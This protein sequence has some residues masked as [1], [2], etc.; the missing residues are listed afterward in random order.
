MYIYATPN[1]VRQWLQ[2]SEKKKNP[3]KQDKEDKP[4]SSCICSRK[5]NGQVKQ[6]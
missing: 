6:R 5:E 1:Q 2:D 3:S 4:T